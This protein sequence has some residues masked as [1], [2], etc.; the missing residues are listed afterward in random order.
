MQKKRVYK[1]AVIALIGVFV[2]FML[3]NTVFIHSH[4]LAD[5]T[6]ISHSHPYNPSTGHTHSANALSLIN[7]FNCTVISFQGLLPLVLALIASLVTIYSCGNIVDV[8]PKENSTASLRA[9]PVL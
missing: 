1:F 2:S 3:A 4:S 8:S 7:A 9:P 6:H 5:G